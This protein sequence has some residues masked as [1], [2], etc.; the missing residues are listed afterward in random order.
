MPT[1]TF[2]VATGARER[3]IAL[4]QDPLKAAFMHIEALEMVL[5]QQGKFLDRIEA[6]E[7][8]WWDKEEMAAAQAAIWNV[9]EAS[10]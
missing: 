7:T 1:D 10:S 5:R 9:L 8:G 3:K 6:A 4:A 2:Q